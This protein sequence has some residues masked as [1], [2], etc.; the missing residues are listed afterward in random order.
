MRDPLC[1]HNQGR[2]T[3]TLFSI[4]YRENDIYGVVNVWGAHGEGTTYHLLAMV[5]EGSKKNKIIVLG[6]LS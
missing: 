5:T 1:G 6:V 3:G 4:S 2:V